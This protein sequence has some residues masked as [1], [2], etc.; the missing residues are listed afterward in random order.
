MKNRSKMGGPV[1]PVNRLMGWE[2]PDFD[3]TEYLKAQEK[4]LHDSVQ[5]N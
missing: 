3:K 4:I 1:A 5:K 2:L